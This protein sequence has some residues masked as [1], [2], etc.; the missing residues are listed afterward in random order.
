[1]FLDYWMNEGG[2]SSTGQLIDFVMTTHP[3]YKELVA[4]SE[5]GKSTYE[6]LGER[7]EALRK[8][9]GAETL[10]KLQWSTEQVKIKWRVSLPPQHTSQRISTSI[11]TCTA[12]APRSQTPR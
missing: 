9:K 10:S 5:E 12:T 4:L 7:L 1:M 8:A 11:Q 2:Q 6:I 3:A